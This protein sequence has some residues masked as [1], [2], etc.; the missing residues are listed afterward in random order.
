M[1]VESAYVVCPLDVH[2]VILKKRIQTHLTKCERQ[3]DMTKKS[4][5]PYNLTHIVDT[6]VFP[7]HLETCPDAISVHQYTYNT[8]QKP[9]AGVLTLEEVIK[10]QEGLDFGEE[11][12]DSAKTGPGY[13][14]NK[15]I[16]EKMII[17]QLSVASKKER[18]D[19]RLAERKRHQLGSDTSS[20]DGRLSSI[21]AGSELQLPNK[22]RLPRSQSKTMSLESISMGKL[23]RELL[24][25]S[26]QNLQDTSTVVEEADVPATKKLENKDS[27][28]KLVDNITDDL[29][30]IKLNDQV[31]NVD[32]DKEK[33]KKKLVEKL[34]R[35]RRLAPKFPSVVD[36]DEKNLTKIPGESYAVLAPW[37]SSKSI[38]N[39]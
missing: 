16:G 39:N 3:H 37:S 21:Y 6:I 13:D 35:L 31:N 20:Y 24:S 34:S 17:R 14:P 22:M 26:Q 7:H 23:K 38:N 5:C 18:K 19:F 4:K 2:H 29:D 25:A 11:N 32:D 27:N 10:H 36:V 12:W 9:L 8:D 30:K 33:S 28:E 15:T 1:P